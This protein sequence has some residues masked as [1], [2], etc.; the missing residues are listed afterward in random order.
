MHQAAYIEFPSSLHQLDHPYMVT[1]PGIKMD[2]PCPAEGLE[3]GRKG[4]RFSITGL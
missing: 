2:G 1:W 3:E 4:F